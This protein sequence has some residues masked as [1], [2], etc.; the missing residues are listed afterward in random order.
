MCLYLGKLHVQINLS[1]RLCDAGLSCRCCHYIVLGP[2]EGERNEGEGVREE[3]NYKD[4]PAFKKLRFLVI[5]NYIPMT[6]N[7]DVRFLV[8]RSVCRLAR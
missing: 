3:V 5:C 2:N 1:R 7:H 8:G 4:A 6:S